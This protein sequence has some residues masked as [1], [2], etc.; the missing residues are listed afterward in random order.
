MHTRRQYVRW[1]PGALAGDVRRPV[2]TRT[3]TQPRD[4]D[5]VP[6]QR[7]ACLLG[8]AAAACLLLLA[9]FVAFSF[10]G[11]GAGGTRA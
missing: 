6:V 11:G 2:S 10:I 3:M 5:V 7:N 9:A 8:G 1:Y 4:A